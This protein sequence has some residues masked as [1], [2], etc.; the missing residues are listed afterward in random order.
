[1]FI[2]LSWRQNVVSV[3]LI[4]GSNVLI[5]TIGKTNLSTRNNLQQQI[6]KLIRDREGFILS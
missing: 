1:M 2:H 6:K 4:R 3:T 5:F